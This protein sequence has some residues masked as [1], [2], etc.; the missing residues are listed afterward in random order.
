MMKKS[1]M[2][3]I[4]AVVAMLWCSC[5]DDNAT[6]VVNGQL[7]MSEFED[8]QVYLCT[9]EHAD[10]LDSAVVKAG[11]FMF[12][13]SVSSPTIGQL[14]CTSRKSGMVCEGTLVL[15]AGKIFIDMV[16]DSL[17]GT[18][19]NDQFYATYIANPTTV[20]L[21]G[22]MEEWLR[23]YYSAE[24]EEQQAAA[25][26]AYLEADSC[27]AAHMLNISRKTY[28]SNSDNI[29]GAYALAM[30]VANDGITYDSLD[31]L[32]SHASPAV[33]DYEPL[34]KARKQLFYLANTAEGKPY[35]DVEG[36]DYA[37]GKWTRLS[38]M[39]DTNHVTLV[40]FWASWCGP[41]RQEIT[42]HLNRLYADYHH[43][44]LDI[45]GLDVWD[46]VDAHHEAVQRL[47]IEYPQL[48][49]TTRTTATEQYGIVSIPMIMLLDRQGNIVHRGLRGA[50]IEEAVKVALGL[51]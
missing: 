5:K 49:D 33:A 50:D 37:T 41:C 40:D 25:K 31:Y 44:G 10:T 22:R 19:L 38:R 2:L 11:K 32:M 9:T 4:T 46:K 27:Y 30:V 34:R 13:G 15:E 23:Q 7:A 24:T 45:I 39:L 6:F 12:R 1:I 14:L 18:P 43:K 36:I 17:S 47:G 51:E 35:V 16:S 29:L 42:D 8:C 21:A 3:V 20:E 48:I 26:T 28:H